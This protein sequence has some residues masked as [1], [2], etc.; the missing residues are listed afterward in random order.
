MGNHSDDQTVM[1]LG[2]G[3]DGLAAWY[4]PSRNGQNFIC[5]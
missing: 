5:F 1:D 3:P 2:C 4:K